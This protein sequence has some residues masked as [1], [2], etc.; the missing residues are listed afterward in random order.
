[1]NVSQTMNTGRPI[2]R[3]LVGRRLIGP[4]AVLLSAGVA[5]AADGPTLPQ[6]LVA[7]SGPASGSAAVDS[8]P[9]VWWEGEAAVASTF[10]ANGPFAAATF[11]DAAAR[12]SGGQ[13]LSGGGKGT[14]RPVTARWAVAVPADGE[15]HLWARKFWRHGAFNWRFDAAAPATVSSTAAA[16]TPLPSTSA[17]STSPAAWRAC[18][19]D[20]A[21]AD[22]VPL[23]TNVSANWVSL[24][25]VSLAKG[26][27]TFEVEVPTEAG[28]DWSAAFDCFV[29]TRGTFVPNGKLKPGEKLGL[30][31]EGFFPF[32][33]DPDPFRPDAALDLRSLNEPAA[34]QAG[35][36]RRRGKDVTLGD[37][38]PARFW[39][40][41]VSPANARQD[42]AS[43]DYLARRLAKLGVNMVR[44]HGQ[45]WSDADPAALDPRKLDD[46]FYLVAALK[47]QGVYTTLS[48]YF[49]VW[50]DGSKLGLDG[51]AAQ[52]GTPAHPNQ[53]PFGLL[54]FDPKL[55][56]LH[57]GWCR[58]LL[59]TPNPYAGGLPLAREP[60][61]GLVEILN[62]DSLFF[63]TFGKTN[64][65]PVQWSRLEDLYNQW[66]VRKHGQV[67]GAFVAWD[68]ER[69][70][71]DA[72]TD[73]AAL[74]EAFHMTAAG[75]KQG[76]AGKAKRVGDQV[77][78]LAEV[79][80]GFYDGAV[81]YLKD[82]L[83]VGGLVSASNW[84]AA[85]PMLLGAVERWT[86]TPGDV[87][88]AHGYFEPE[89]KGDGATFSV[90]VG[91]TVVE[92]AAVRNPGLVPL[93]FQQVENY[94]QFASE[95]GFTQPNRQRADG[96][97]LSAAYGSL[98]GVDGLFFFAV[99]SNTLRDASITKFQIGSPAVAQTFPAAALVYR[100]GMVAE[101]EPAVYQVGP[102][103]DLWALKGAGGWS[104][105]ALDGFRRADVPAG[106]AAGGA[107]AT[108]SVGGPVD[109]VDGY[110]PFVGPVVRGFEQPASRSY[111][112]DLP[113]LIDR[114]GKSIASL[115]GE[116]RWDH[117]RGVAVMN[118]PR[119]QGAAGY[120]RDAGPVA[121]ADTKIALAA[122]FGT[123]TVAAMDGK[124]IRDSRRVLVQVMTQDQ[125]YGY[126]LENNT[127]ANLGS[128]PFGVRTIA[129]SVELA[130]GPQAGPPG[131]P[132]TG[133]AGP[134]AR[135]AALDPNGYA[136][137]R[138][139]PVVAT[140]GGGVKIDL[141]P[142][143][144]YYV[145]TR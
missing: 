119:A 5:A 55:Q 13:W 129:G 51:F 107:A 106:A 68:G 54:F 27:R 59:T 29:L 14:G 136:T 64:L 24:G 39:A 84:T 89:H 80:R 20:V 17:P 139:V 56:T 22:D 110:T 49:P 6:S 65:P 62:E 67:A 3:R 25:T 105:D 83:K 103:A 102:V 94:P 78:F 74:Y 26:D 4:T 99:G 88:D 127:I 128:A 52:G 86:Y 11:P 113:R 23:R 96:T 124:P 28:K 133:A 16:S 61:V 43:V 60:A 104:A 116:L 101:A 37:G 45:L 141:L 77:Q 44:V 35:F 93:R 53:K 97:F 137:S 21:L 85:D 46:L 71:G 76:G 138:P 8:P 117:G 9:Y 134:P 98:Q 143:V 69:A 132:A 33:P 90:R 145:V 126:R 58:Q 92:R 135:V 130:F 32:E 87:I 109:K 125:P 73:R 7:A 72:G 10:P 48:F 95:I 41:N 123:V 115:T 18:G 40:V 66:L 122:E 140:A 31:D 15:Y 108:A 50:A 57:R 42:R 118:A 82:D 131:G 121:T 30:A 120:L 144:L 70:K 75:V 79:Q 34:G 111:Q 38:T 112:R 91:Q 36:L 81:R 63:W 47:R 114:P 100:T 142:D 12:L 1:M 19:P 2:G